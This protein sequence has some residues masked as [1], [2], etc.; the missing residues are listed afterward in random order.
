[1]ISN[2]SETTSSRTTVFR[3][4]IQPPEYGNTVLA[5]SPAVQKLTPQTVPPNNVKLLFPPSEPTTKKLV[6]EP[7]P[8][9][10]VKP[11]TLAPLPSI[12]QNLKKEQD[13]ILVPRPQT[14]T[15]RVQS[16]TGTCMTVFKYTVP[17]AHRVKVPVPVAQQK[18]VLPLT[19]ISNRQETIPQTTLPIE[20]KSRPMLT[21]T[22][23]KML[24]PI[25]HRTE[26]IPV[27][28]VA[29]HAKGN[30]IY[31]IRHKGGDPGNYYYKK[32]PAVAKR[33]SKRPLL[34]TTIKFVECTTQYQPII[35][36]VLQNTE[37]VFIPKV[38]ATKTE[39]QTCKP[40]SS[41]CS[42]C[43]F[44]NALP[45]MLPNK[46]ELPPNP[47]PPINLDFP[48]GNNDTSCV[49]INQILNFTSAP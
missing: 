37:K 2:K 36:T 18:T 26:C 5:Q 38:I 47:M 46:V 43:D 35:Q 8:N 6:P 7:T 23:P 12:E 45:E 24:S 39:T 30:K 19:P 21:Q 1:M 9:A 27:P 17:P 3:N 4:S 29:G 49:D 14:T 44:G 25:I 22:T 34:C 20:D 28:V 13:I 33:F 31:P 41:D 48:K 32:Q 10:T 16:T 40:D 11:T 15:D 42:S